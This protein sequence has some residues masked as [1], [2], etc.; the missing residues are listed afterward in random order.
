M[1]TN[2]RHSKVSPEELARKWNVGLQMAKDTLAATTQDGV[3]TAAHLMTR[4]VKVDHMRLHR[5]RL[6]GLWFCDTLISKIKSLLGNT[7][8]NVF[9]QG[10]FTKVVPAAAK[11]DAGKTL[12]EFTNDVGIPEAMIADGAGEFTGKNTDFVKEAR[13]MR[14]KMCTT[15]Q[16]RKNQNHAAEQEIVTLSK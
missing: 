4:Q 16:G 2:D 12:V 3:R 6:R 8:A 5:P 7:C 13:R 1:I 15:E 9:T 11:S 14:I 10:K